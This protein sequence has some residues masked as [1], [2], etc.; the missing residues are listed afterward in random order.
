MH[1]AQLR[2]I[3][4]ARTNHPNA[5]AY[6]TAMLRLA[7]AEIIASMPY[8]PDLG[9]ASTHIPHLFSLLQAQRVE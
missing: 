9:T 5:R 3:K 4:V 2:V 8:V 6:G 1:I 7:E